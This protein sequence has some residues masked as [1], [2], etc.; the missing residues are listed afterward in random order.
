MT[1]PPARVR[2]PKGDFTQSQIAEMT[3]RQT[4]LLEQS[5]ALGDRILALKHWEQPRGDS[6]IRERLELARQLA[7][8]QSGDRS[9]LSGSIE[10]HVRASPLKT[11]LSDD[12]S[13]P[14]DGPGAR[15][16]NLAGG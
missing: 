9:L 2:L 11:M 10:D 1:R 6:L 7:Y 3:K 8:E 13:Q 16:N 5:D 4:E 14:D 15:P 12:P